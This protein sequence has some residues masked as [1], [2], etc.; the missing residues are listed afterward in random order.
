MLRPALAA[1]AASRPVTRTG[2]TLPGSTVPRPR[3]SGVAPWAQRLTLCKRAARVATLERG[4][5]PLPK[6]SVM[7]TGACAAAAHLPTPQ[8]DSPEDGERLLY[9]LKRRVLS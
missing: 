9:L 7:W 2:H 3:V 8:A 5:A 4:A 6:A 1:R